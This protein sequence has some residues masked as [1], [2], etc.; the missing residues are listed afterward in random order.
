MTGGALLIGVG[1]HVLVCLGIYLCLRA[2]VLK[3]SPQMFPLVVLVPPWGLL[4][5]AAAEWNTRRHKAGV[6][7]IDLDDLHISDYRL[8]GIEEETSQAPV[9]PLEEAFLI[10]DAV[11][12]RQLMIEILRQDPNQYIQL[13]QQARLNDDI[14]VTHYASTAMMEVQREYEI[15]LQRCERR[16]AEEPDS[17]R[18]LDNCLLALKRY[19]DSGLLEDS[20]LGVQRMRY[21]DLL[22]RKRAV[23]EPDRRTWFAAAENRLAL[24]QFG[25]A[26]E[27]IG[28]CLAQWPQDENAWLLQLQYGFLTDDGALIRRTAEEIQRR[29]IYL[30]AAGREALRFWAA[31]D[32]REVREA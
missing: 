6:N 16:L 20:V 21:G 14:E 2:G 19:I 30:S 18:A 5:A 27:L 25:L 22:D 12:R 8:L 10:N 4:A 29:E 15:D 31:P 28:G 26:A 13:L 32:E 7:S 3:F 24:R 9:V 1:L 17:A 23:G 11:T